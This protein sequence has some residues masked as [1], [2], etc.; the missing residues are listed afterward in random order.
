MSSQPPV[1]FRPAQRVLPGALGHTS[2]TPDRRNPSFFG[3]GLLSVIPV[4]VFF[5]VLQIL[6]LMDGDR[7]TRIENI[8]FWPTLGGIVLALALYNRSLLDK[9]FILSPPVASL[10]AYMLFAGASIAWALSPEFAF[11]RYVVQLLTVVVVLVPYALPIDTD[12]T[13]ARLH[14]CSLFAVGVNAIYVLTTPGSSIGHYGLFLHKQVLGIV[15][16]TAIILGLHELFFRGWRRW[17]GVVT[18]CLTFW[19]IFESQSKGA[20]SLLLVALSFSVVLLILGKLLRTSPAIVV[21]TGVLT[22]DIL[23]R[24]WSD[25]MGRI[26]WYLYGDA[27]LSGRT[28]IWEFINYQVLQRTWFGWGFRSYWGVP[29][30][31]HNQ[32]WGFVKDMISSHSGYL[33]LRLETGHIGY[34]IFLVFVYASLHILERLRRRDPL[35]AYVFTAISMYMILLNFMESL[36]LQTS[37][38][39]ILYLTT[40]AESVR[41]SRSENTH[42]PATRQSA[43]AKRHTGASLRRAPSS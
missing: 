3:R 24:F 11:S 41:I 13:V 39:W 36:W 34:W 37:P 27:T 25:P 1:R 14:V 2:S 20:L 17:L 18:I 10:V 40:V 6:P 22:I 19:V 30:S 33:E 42:L 15:C 32:A 23:S 16:G 43:P 4:I 29:D 5:Y 35:R 21:G 8:L 26:A 9:G 28:H 7:G 38:L 12:R 31:P